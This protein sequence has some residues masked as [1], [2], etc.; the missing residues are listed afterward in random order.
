MSEAPPDRRTILTVGHS[1]HPI[2]QLLWLL[3][4][5]GVALLV[6]VRSHPASRYAPRFEREALTWVV[7]EAGI[8][9][10]FLGKELG[11]RPA[12]KTLYDEDGHVDYARVARSS[13]FLRGIGRLIDAAERDTVAILCGEEDPTDCHRRLLV[14]RVL[15]QRGIGVRHIRGDGHLET[16]AEWAAL[17]P[18]LPALQPP[19]FD[20]PQDEVWRSTRPVPRVREP[21]PA[22]RASAVGDVAACTIGFARKSA[23]AF[24][25][26]LK[27]AGVR[28]LLDVRL[29]NT[30]QL[31]GFTKRDDLR[32]FLREICGADYVH[33][34][35]LAPTPDLLGVYRK[36]GGSWDDYERG[37]LELMAGRKIEEKIDRALF[38][39][40]TVLLCS[41]AAAERCHRRLVLEY[42]GGIWGNLHI[43]HL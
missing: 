23:D 20:A 28:R 21:G 40:P 5:H 13:L 31:A 42:L 26:A 27:A 34:P 35:L 29:R 19:L 16:E 32:F 25:G 22:F 12:N 3:R 43:T 6:D 11:G 2:E 8:A 39:I 30:S 10:L 18:D 4:Q 33:E 1:N 17:T 15:A 38:E 24:F 36:A 9:Y 41:E 7:T 37:F 14:G